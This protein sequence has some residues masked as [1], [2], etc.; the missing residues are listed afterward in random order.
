MGSVSFLSTVLPLGLRGAPSS[1]LAEKN[2][3]NENLCFQ[4]IVLYLPIIVGSCSHDLG[5]AAWFH[6]NF[7]FGSNMQCVLLSR[8]TLW[9]SS[10]NLR[11][12]EK[13]TFLY[14]VR[15]AHLLFIAP[16]VPFCQ[17]ASAWV[18]KSKICNRWSH[19]EVKVH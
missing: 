18:Q 11:T 9:L 6:Y 19:I 4:L 5:P 12:R 16:G 2:L 17:T 10:S 14:W 7:L 13:Y 8:A 1:S 15:H 3:F